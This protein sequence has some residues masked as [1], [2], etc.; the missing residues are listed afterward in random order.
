MKN[1]YVHI[2]LHTSEVLEI[3]GALEQAQKLSLDKLREDFDSIRG[4]DEEY[5]QMMPAVF[6]RIMRKFDTAYDDSTSSS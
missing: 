4:I 2:V 1:D 3:L 6:A 5:H